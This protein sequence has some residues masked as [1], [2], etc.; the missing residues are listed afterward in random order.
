MIECDQEI[1][2]T[3]RDINT[4]ID[5]QMNSR[6]FWKVGSS[7]T[8]IG[9]ACFTCAAVI[10][11]PFTA[12]WS[13]GVLTYSVPATGLGIAGNKMLDIV[14]ALDDNGIIDKIK[15]CAQRHDEM[16]QGLQNIVGN[17]CAIVDEL[18]TEHGL[19]RRNAWAVIF[20]A[21]V[22]G[23]IEIAEVVISANVARSAANDLIRL[24]GEDLGWRDYLGIKDQIIIKIIVILFQGTRCQF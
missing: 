18:M 1:I 16:A 17:M 14:S 15:R 6:K 2:L 3:L 22:E 13:L 12:G 19:E 10:A 21:M 11:A 24:M 5:D 8:V 9:G 4:L 7:T 20:V 23:F